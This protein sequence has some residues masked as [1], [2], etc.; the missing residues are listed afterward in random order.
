M[1]KNVLCIGYCFVFVA[2]LFVDSAVAADDF[3]IHD[4]DRVVIY[5]DSITDN[6]LYPQIIEDFIVTRHPNWDVQV[7]NRGWGGDMAHYYGRFQRDCLSLKPTVVII[8][9]GMNDAWYV[10]FDKARFEEYVYYLDRMAKDLKAIGSRVVFVS[11]PTYDLAQQQNLLHSGDQKVYEMSYYPEVLREFSL[12]MLA[13][14]KVNQ[15]TYIDLNNSYSILLAIGRARHGAE[16]RMS[17]AGD[18]V[19]PYGP[20]QL[21]MAAF[22]LQGL[23]AP[24]EVAYV[25]IDA[26]AVQATEVRSTKISD[27]SFDGKQMSFNRLDTALPMPAYEQTEPVGEMLD[28]T[29]RFNRNVLRIQ[30]LKPGNYKLVVD[31]R[32]IVTLDANAW[33]EG[34]NLCR[35]VFLP[36]MMHSKEVSEATKKL[37]EARYYKWRKVL[38]KNIGWVGSD[39]AYDTNDKKE[40]KKAGEA[41]ETAQRT[42]KELSKPKV[43][44]YVLERVNQ[45]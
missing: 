25:V 2:A 36:E 23:N 30:N 40:L 10:P 6:Q 5:G 12:G 43:R 27:L 38:C 24:S 34:T 16:F 7:W 41:I 19:H 11:P 26:K 4:G 18:A 15:C 45:D 44:R 35:R 22:I 14:A 20:G 37:H 3:L 42:R 21:A 9:L 33:Q 31:D 32:H 29:D 17:R 39:A 28:L 1:K 13:A 8:C